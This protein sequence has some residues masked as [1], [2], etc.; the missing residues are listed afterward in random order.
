MFVGCSEISISVIVKHVQHMGIVRAFV[1]LGGID[2]FFSAWGGHKKML[3]CGLLG[4]AGSLPRL[5]L[6]VAV[7]K[8]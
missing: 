2:K 3:G 7:T 1:S 6:W 5:T 4:G 8:P